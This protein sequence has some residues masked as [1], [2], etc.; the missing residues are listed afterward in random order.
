MKTKYSLSVEYSQSWHKAGAYAYALRARIVDAVNIP[1]TVFVMHRGRRRMGDERLI[2]NFDHIATPLDIEELPTTP[3]DAVS[4]DSTVQP[5]Y[6][7]DE[8]VIWF[9]CLD[10]LERAKKSIDEDIAS[11]VET[12]RKLGNFSGFVNTETVVHEK[13]VE[14]EQDS[15][16]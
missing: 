4:L 15:N 3:I 13:E 7:V 9:R 6:L 5:Y 11:L 1:S 12:Y 14:E 2:D 8:I 16:D 10:D